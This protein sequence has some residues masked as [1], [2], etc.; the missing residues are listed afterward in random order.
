MRSLEYRKLATAR[1]GYEGQKEND[2][3]APSDQENAEHGLFP[4]FA[5][6]QE[7]SQA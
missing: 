5:Q 4:R 6:L 3:L 1:P 2:S 7:Q